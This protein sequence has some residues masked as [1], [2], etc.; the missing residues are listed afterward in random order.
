MVPRQH[1]RWEKIDAETARRFTR[2]RP[3]GHQAR[4]NRATVLS[5]QQTYRQACAGRAKPPST[6]WTGPRLPIKCLIVALVQFPSKQPHLKAV[7]HV[8]AKSRQ[9]GTYQ[10]MGIRG[11]HWCAVPEPDFGPGIRSGFAAIHPQSAASFGNHCQSQPVATVCSR[12]ALLH[13][14]LLRTERGRGTR[15][16]NAC[17]AICQLRR[18]ER[19]RR[20]LAFHGSSQ[21]PRFNSE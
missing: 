9:C 8:S 18:T 12:L 16:E 17:R 2:F 6:L 21:V 20:D 14:D 13:H 10:E 1:T 5:T 3:Y 7:M 11:D 15:E 4:S 19:G